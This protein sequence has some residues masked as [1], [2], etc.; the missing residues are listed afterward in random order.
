MAS[1]PSQKGHKKRNS[2]SSSSGKQGVHYSRIG[3]VQSNTT[4][5]ANNGSVQNFSSR[6]DNCIRSSYSGMQNSALIS[7]PSYASRMENDMKSNC[8]AYSRIST[9]SS[10]VDKDIRSNLSSD[11]YSRSYA[12]MVDNYTR[13]VTSSVS[14]SSLGSLPSWSS[15]VDSGI[16]SRASQYGY[17]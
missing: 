3:S 15:Q 7:Y 12:S 13:S 11:S 6:V 16:R 1:Y 8:M 14:G 10:R 17:Y 9:F 2:N 4:N 5:Y